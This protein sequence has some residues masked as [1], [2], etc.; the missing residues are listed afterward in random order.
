VK[1][2]EKNEK[3]E[4]EREREEIRDFKRIKR[5]RQIEKESLGWERKKK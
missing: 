4:M 1:D 2:K 3:E 5:E